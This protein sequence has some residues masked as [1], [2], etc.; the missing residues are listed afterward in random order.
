MGFKSPLFLLGIGAPGVTT[1]GGFRTPIPGWNAGGTTT[2]IQAGFV[3]PLPFMFG[4]AGIGE[5]E[6]EVDAKSYTHDRFRDNHQQIMRDDE[7]L[8]IIAR[9]FIEIIRCRH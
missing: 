9:A 1:Q 3:S 8:L 7:E 6:P 5:V 4:G 2:G